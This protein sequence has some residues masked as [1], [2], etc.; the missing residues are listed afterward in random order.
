MACASG[1]RGQG[2]LQKKRGLERSGR[3]TGQ[4]GAITFR[5]DS[6]GPEVVM[7]Q[8]LT[9]VLGAM[10]LTVSMDHLPLHELICPQ[11]P[12][13]NRNAWSGYSQL[14]HTGKSVG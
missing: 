3:S 6:Q 8:M 4:A 14:W 11:G 1:L 9:L 13:K 10:L 12:G 5:K 7:S 2:V